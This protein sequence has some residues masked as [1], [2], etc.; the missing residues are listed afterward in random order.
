MVNTRLC[1]ELRETAGSTGIV[2]EENSFP[3]RSP[4]SWSFRNVMFKDEERINRIQTLVESLQDGSRSKSITKDLKQEG[5]F[6]V[7]SKASKRNVEL[8]ELGE[9]VRTTQCPTCLAT[10]QRSDSFSACAVRV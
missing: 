1:K 3:S 8:Y 5:L 6:N 4:S 10:F 7:F 2:K 9:T